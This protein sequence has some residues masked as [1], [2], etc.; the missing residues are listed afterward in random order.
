MTD[1]NN[2]STSTR[3]VNTRPPGSRTTSTRTNR[4]TNSN[5]D[6]PVKLNL[7]LHTVLIFI[8]SILSFILSFFIS[9]SINYGYCN[10]SN[11]ELCDEP[12]IETVDDKDY[13][14][15]KDKNKYKPIDFTY[16]INVVIL[17][18]VIPTMIGSIGYLIYEYIGNKNRIYKDIAFIINI[19]LIIVLIIQFTLYNIYKKSCMHSN[20]RCMLTSELK[21]K[22]NALGYVEYDCVPN[23][24]V[25][26]NVNYNI[27][28]LT[29]H[30]LKS[31]TIFVVIL[32]F[33]LIDKQIQIPEDPANKI[34]KNIN[35]KLYI[36]IA[37]II[38]IVNLI[39]PSTYVQYIINTLYILLAI[40][41]IIYLRYI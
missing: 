32:T 9:K 28:N 39:F 2:S 5:N 38:F 41:V 18:L 29:N 23:I 3:T 22:D 30:I 8:L 26:S 17:P 25:L 13:M 19:L 4:S 24:R 40:Y 10:K 37:T 11:D 12:S 21:L 31:I 35:E 20:Y 34:T 14:T 16:I 27:V 6:P 1:S 7:K 36:I 15:C 33:Y